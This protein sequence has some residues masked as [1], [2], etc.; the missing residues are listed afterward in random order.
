[1][2][3]PS[4]KESNTTCRMLRD[5]S[6]KRAPQATVS[7]SPATP[8]TTPQAMTAVPIHPGLPCGPAGMP[9]RREIVHDAPARHMPAAKTTAGERPG[10]RRCN[11][12]T[13]ATASTAS[14]SCEA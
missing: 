11:R 1:M 12:P 13:S 14:V 4:K 3:Y 2:R 7:T 10:C 9:I 8:Y 6:E 5:P